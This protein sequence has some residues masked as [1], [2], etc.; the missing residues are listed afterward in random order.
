MKPR[1][2]EHLHAQKRIRSNTE[3]QCHANEGPQAL[4]L[5]HVEQTPFY[6]PVYSRQ[7]VWTCFICLY[8]GDPLWVR[9]RCHLECLGAVPFRYGARSG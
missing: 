7:Y 2:S 1:M 9:D 8:W 5:E 3:E 6:A 4:E